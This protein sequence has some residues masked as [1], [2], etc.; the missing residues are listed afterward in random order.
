MNARSVRAI[1]ARWAVFARVSCFATGAAMITVGLLWAMQYLIATGVEAVTEERAFRFV[2]FI[3]L[4]RDERV[5]TR[6]ERVER[7]PD[8]HAPPP[9]QPRHELSDVDTAGI[10]VIGVPAPRLSHEVALGREAFFSD[11]D[12]MPIVQVA[13]QYPYRAANLG[14]EGFVLLEFTVTGTGMVRDPRV[15]ESSNAI[16]DQAALDAVLR[17]RY[18]PRIIDGEPVVVPGVRFRITFELWDG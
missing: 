9:L 2:D 3:R 13:P 4:Q 7:V 16:F 10:G 12:Y 18:R 11:G 17:F 1:G 8:A 5:Q 6:E 14:L 15:I